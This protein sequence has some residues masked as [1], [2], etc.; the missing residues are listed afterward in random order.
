M[1]EFEWSWMYSFIECWKFVQITVS[2]MLLGLAKLLSM[3]IIIKCVKLLKNDSILL[4]VVVWYFKSI[5][6]KV[7]GCGDLHK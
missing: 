1:L 3:Q 7:L 5:I 2:L 6:Q 4:Y